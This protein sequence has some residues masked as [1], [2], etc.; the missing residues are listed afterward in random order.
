[1]TRAEHAKRPG[2]SSRWIT[3]RNRL[4]IYIR[5]GF[6]CCYCGRDLRNARPNDVG[7]DHLKPQSQGGGH[8]HSNLVTACFS[9]NRGRSVTPWHRYATPGAVT[10]IKRLRRR[11][12]NLNLAS[13]IL[14]GEVSRGDALSLS[15]W[16][17]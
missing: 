14:R 3:P 4:A 5:D 11:A 6:A 8:E 7:L 1:M 12:C 17:R 2:R 16:S 15:R 13:A 10:R 9:C